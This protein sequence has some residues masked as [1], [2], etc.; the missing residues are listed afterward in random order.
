MG[1]AKDFIVGGLAIGL[2]FVLAGTGLGFLAAPLFAYGVGRIIGKLSQIFLGMENRIA[3]AKINVRTTQASIPVI[4]GRSRVGLRLNDMRIINSND[5]ATPNAVPAD[6]FPSGGG[7]DEDEPAD[8]NDILVKVGAVALGSEDG[9]GIQEISHVRAYNDDRDVIITLGAGFSAA[10]SS[11]GV[12]PDFVAHL[13]YIIEDGDDVQ[14]PRQELVDA[15]GW[16][17]GGVGPFNGRGVAYAAFFSFYNTDTWMQGIPQYTMRVTGSR[18]YDPRSA[19]FIGFFNAAVPSSDNPALCI[20]D[21]LT[22]KRYGG[23]VPYAA[24]DGGTD[25]FIDEQS[26]IDAANYC[27]DQIPIQ[28][29]GTEKRFRMNAVIDTGQIVGQNLAEMMATCRGQLIWQNGLYRIVISQV[30]TPEAF[31]LTEDNIVGPLQWTRKGAAIPNYIECAFNDSLNNDYSANTVSWPLVGD[32]T[33]L[34]EDNG[35][36][37]RAEV[38]LPYTTTFLQAQRTVMV[39]LR[40]AR[41]D[42]FVNLQAT[43]AAY[44]LQVGNVV[45]VTHEGPGW[46]QLEFTVKQMSLLPDGLVGLSL[47]QYTAAAYNLDTLAAQPS[48]PTTNLPDPTSIDP[49]TAFNLTADETTTLL[50]QDGQAV[51]RIRLQWTPPVDPFLSHYECQFFR[52]SVPLELEAIANPQK[53]DDNVFIWPVTEAEDYTVQIRAV[54]SL[55]VKSDFVTDTVTVVSQGQ[56][57]FSLTATLDVSQSAVLEAD[58]NGGVQSYKIAFEKGFSPITEPTDT[59][60]RARPF[61]NGQ[62]LSIADISAAYV[63]IPVGLQEGEGCIFKAFAYSLPGGVGNESTLPVTAFVTRLANLVF[64]QLIGSEYFIQDVE[65][66]QTATIVFDTSEGRRRIEDAVIAGGALGVDT[67]TDEIRILAAP[68]VP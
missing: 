39:M 60:V 40:E 51:P 49:P 12:D 50:T 63:D 56:P 41:N 47:Q 32:L 25:D 66:N 36:E 61:V 27:D 53:F 10:P 68:V 35:V 21:Y 42:V 46:D 11:S 22:S 15:L 13:K 5:L 59:E 4:Y 29:S 26:F 2:S 34:N 38:S 62:I 64:I 17:V 55:G 24:R 8:N 16:D 37:N 14:T 65:A 18:V 30:T 19:T 67:P 9:S 23:G 20:L 54:N 1:D 52:T 7:E 58:G 48:A 43:A 6:I 31:E 3:G 44:V 28:P 33:L 45:R 57:Q